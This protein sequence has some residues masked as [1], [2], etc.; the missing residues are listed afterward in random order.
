MCTKRLPFTLAILICVFYSCQSDQSKNIHKDAQKFFQD[1]RKTYGGDAIFNSL[2]SFSSDGLDYKIERKGN[3]S[4]YFMSKERD[5]IRYYTTYENG[6]IQY[7]I[8]DTLQ[9]DNTYSRKFF[10]I[11]LDGFVYTTFIPHVFNGNDIL[12]DRLEKKTIRNVEYEVLYVHTKPV[13]DVPTDEFYLYIDP[14]SNYI[15]YMAQNHTLSNP[16]PIFKKFHNFR[17]I[18]EIIF[19]DYFT[20]RS[21]DENSPLDSLYIQYEYATLREL[22]PTEFTDINV[23]LLPE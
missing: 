6:F 18:N 23:Q 8:N 3:I 10:D 20:F 4:N 13:E 14:S 16:A 2:I 15:M 19:A 9:D 1:V 5:D 17:E 21:K 22:Q 7:F 11:K 12:I